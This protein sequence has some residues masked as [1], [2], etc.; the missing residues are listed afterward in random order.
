[1]AHLIVDVQDEICNPQ[2]LRGTR[3][4]GRT[5]RRIAR[6]APLF[7]RAGLTTFW[8]YTDRTFEGPQT[9]GGGFYAV[10][11]RRTG[12]AILLPKSRNSAFAGTALNRELKERGITTLLISGFN[13]SA[14]VIETARAARKL[15]YTVIILR[16]CT[17]DDSTNT[18]YSAR[19][20]RFCEQKG[21]FRDSGSVLE[22]L[23]PAPR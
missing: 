22:S 8:I 18:E 14:C 23:K 2:G 15:G 7:N 10:R 20:A 5:A 16:D 13:L 19:T 4:T 9:A 6:L 1:M 11:P 17:A 21:L 3:E 12:R